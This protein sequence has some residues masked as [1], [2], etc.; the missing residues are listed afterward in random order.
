[1]RIFLV[2]F[3]LFLSFL[4]NTLTTEMVKAVDVYYEFEPT[5][6]TLIAVEDPNVNYGYSTHM[7]IRND[8][9]GGFGLEDLICFNISNITSGSVVTS[10]AVYLYYYYCD[11]HKP[12]GRSLNIYRVTSGWDEDTVTWNTQPSCAAQPTSNAIVPSF[13]GW[14]SWDVTSDVQGFVNGSFDNF[15]WKI[16]DNNYWSLINIPQVYFQTKEY[17]A[18]IPY[19]KVVVS[20]INVSGAPQINVSDDTNI[21]GGT[22]SVL[23]IPTDDSK[24]RMTVPDKT[25]GSLELSVRNTYGGTSDDWQC[26]TL[27]KFDI[28]SVPSKSLIVSAT[29]SLYY[30]DW[31]Q[32]DPSGRKLDLYRLTENWDEESVTWNSKPSYDSQIVSS[33]II[34]SSFQ[35]VFWNVTNDVQDFIDGLKTN[36]GWLLR[37]NNYWGKADIPETNFYSKENDNSIPY[38]EI[39]Y[40]IFSNYTDVPGINY[41]VSYDESLVGYW[42]F[43]EGSGTI[44][45]DISSYENNGSIYGNPQWID[46]ISGKALYFDGINDYVDLG[47]PTILNPQNEIT[48]AAWYKTVSFSGTGANPIVD[49]GGYSHTYP[50]YQYHLGVCGNQYEPPRAY[51]RFNWGLTADGVGNGTYTV[52]DFWTPGNWYYI[53]GTYNGSMINLYVN[54]NNLMTLISSVPLNGT[55]Q[56]YGKNVYIA[57]YSNLDYFTPGIIDE[58]RIYNRALSAD[59][60]QYLY[61][62]PVNQPPSNLNFTIINSTEDTFINENS[63]NDNMGSVTWLRVRGLTGYKIYTLIK[64]N[65]SS[66]TLGT[67]IDSAT[68]NIY[69][70]LE[71]GEGNP[72]GQTLEIYKILDNWNEHEVTWNI[73]PGHNQFI[74]SSAVVPSNPNVWMRWNVTNDVQYFINNP[75]MNYG[76]KIIDANDASDIP[77]FYSKEYGNFIPYLEIIVKQP[78]SEIELGQWILNFLI[79]ALTIIIIFGLGDVI[80]LKNKKK[81]IIKNI[82]EK[83]KKEINELIIEITNE[84]NK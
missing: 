83:E 32:N 31:N 77:Y 42:S 35:T 16:A 80:Y 45:H 37:D 75:G 4:F 72:V 58:V 63:P 70:R 53:V 55:M 74:T 79:V 56:D 24:I 84:K 68:L 65:L 51:A 11:D 61:N 66:I 71:E 22:Y 6:D 49:K 62:N 60:I 7:V 67:H 3:L 41:N 21:A 34:P 59:E 44:V 8:S 33:A 17:G 1:M 82:I 29:L 36:Y 23:L 43:D 38:L 76:W 73:Q 15:G 12:D 57:K 48:V 28:S 50:Y 46:G 26:D 9:Y 10:A 20:Q 78:T 19:L 39:V 14:M 25:H 40:S 13:Y 52:N 27:I 5:D 54:I 18:Y 2:L 81:K 47:N 69:Y 64:F 30:Y